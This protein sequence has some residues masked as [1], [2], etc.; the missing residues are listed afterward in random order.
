MLPTNENLIYEESKVTMY[1]KE[2]QFNPT[3]EH[4]VTNPDLSV[5]GLP[6]DVS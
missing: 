4:N 6:D 2:F 5:G 3:Q 1:T